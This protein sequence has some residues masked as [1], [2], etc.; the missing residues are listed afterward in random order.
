MRPKTIP[1]FY[2]GD[3]K[4]LAKR[5][6]D[7]ILYED[8]YD[9]VGDIGIPLGW[10]GILRHHGYI[11]VCSISNDNMFSYRSFLSETAA[12]KC[13][14]HICDKYEKYYIAQE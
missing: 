2:S 9:E 13:W 8:I 4:V 6:V 5:L 12:R 1:S 14:D 10:S 11:Y 7:R 3:D